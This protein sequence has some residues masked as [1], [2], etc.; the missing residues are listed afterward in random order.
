MNALGKTLVAVVI[1]GSAVA[2]YRLRE[3]KPVVPIVARATVAKGDIV[4]V[5]SATGTLAA[6]RSV[7]VGSQ[8]SGTVKKLLV[9]YNA[10]VKKGQ[11]L[12]QIDPD[13]A[14]T[15]L[16]VAEASEQQAKSALVQDEAKRDNDARLLTR[17]EALVAD[18]QET[19]EDRDEAKL[20]VQEDGTR[21]KQDQAAIA[22][23]ETSVEQAKIAIEHC[24]ITSPIDGVVVARD[25]DEGQTLVATVTSPTIYELASDLTDMQLVGATDEADVSGVQKGQLARFTVDAYPGQTFPGVVREVRLNPTTVNNVVTYQTIIDVRNPNLQL[26]PGMTA[27]FLLETGRSHDVLKVPVSALRFYPTQSALPVFPDTTLPTPVATPPTIAVGAAGRVWKVDGRRLVAV[28]VTLGRTDG[29]FVE[30]SGADLHET[31]EVI[32]AIITPPRR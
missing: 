32:T 3:P 18:A 20:V 19:I 14:Q 29:S 7:A 24:T 30:V 6:A 4:Q 16:E 10:V 25:V 28:K 13:R 12:A 1:T 23:T 27:H 22:I 2:A 9:D 31:D 15:Q 5:V 21:I 11:V 17:M 8:V 26:M